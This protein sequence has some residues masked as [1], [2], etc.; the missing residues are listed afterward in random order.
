MTLNDIEYTKAKVRHLQTNGICERFHKAILWEFYQ[1]TF[2]LK[3]YRLIEEL[4]SDLDDWMEYDN[5]DRRRQ[6]NISCGRKPKQTI[7]EEM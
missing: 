5:N 2:R 7:I 3:L 1:V 6:A 4:Q